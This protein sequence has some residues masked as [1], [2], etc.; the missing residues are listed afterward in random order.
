MP[1]KNTGNRQQNGAYPYTELYQRLKKHLDSV[2]IVDCHEHLPT[3]ANPKTDG[4]EKHIGRFFLHYAGCDLVSAGMPQADLNAVKSSDNKLSPA[5]RWKKIRPWYEKAWNTAYCECLRIAIRDLYG[6]ED[7]SDKTV[8]QL[9]EAIEKNVKPGFMRKVFDKAR[10]DIA[11]NNL[12][13]R[14]VFYADQ[15]HDCF[16]PDMRD[17]FTNFPFDDFCGESGLEIAC[18]DDYL[19][20]IDWYFE[21]YGK[22][23]GAFKVGRAYDRTLLWQDV[24]RSDAERV[25]NRMLAFNDRPDRKDVQALEDFIM[26]IL[27]RKCGECGLRMKFHTGIQEGNGNIITNSRAALL[28]NLFM[29]YPKTGFDI[30]HISYPYQEE[31]VAIAKNFP[32]V[33]IDFCWMWIINPAAARR[34][35]SDMLDAVPANKILG[36]GGDF[37]FVEGSY[38]HAQVARRQIARVLAEK[39][40]EGRFSEDYAAQVGQMLLRDNAIE[41]FDLAKRR[42]AFAGMKKTAKRV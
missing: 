31:L 33:T 27:C 42:K 35:L 36:F 17:S 41:C 13:D 11:M 1:D 14:P 3:E 16:I 29:K 40:Q 22:V 20:M 37:L 10:I 26:H 7:F 34:A 28:A 32:N 5:D 21:R 4:M 30:F 24:P 18:L 8:N 9:Q 25:F 2:A 12:W 19:E 15:P 38:G 6:I 39:V 23:A